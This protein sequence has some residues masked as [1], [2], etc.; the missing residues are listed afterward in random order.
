MR[1][2]SLHPWLVAAAGSPKVCGACVMSGRFSCALAFLLRARIGL[3]F[4][5]QHRVRQRAPTTTTLRSRDGRDG[6]ASAAAVGSGAPVP[7]AAWI[8]HPRWWV[9]GG[10][11][12]GAVA[13]PHWEEGDASAV[14]PSSVNASAHVCGPTRT[15]SARPHARRPA[16]T[17]GAAPSH[18]CPHHHRA[19]IPLQGPPPGMLTW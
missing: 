1:S 3:R 19:A 7:P 8:S 6:P 12:V 16:F 4:T 14:R 10:C 11:R 18:P 13:G 5:H 17:P 9:A 15:R 2:L